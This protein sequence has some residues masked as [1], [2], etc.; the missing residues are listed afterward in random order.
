MQRFQGTVQDANGR[1]VASATVTVFTSGVVNPL[2]VIYHAAGSKT[3]PAV[4]ANPITTD[5]LGNFGFA[6]P[7]GTY[8]VVISG[9]GIPTKTLPNINFF[10]GGITYPSPMLGTVTSVSMTAPALFTV[11]GSPITGS[12]TLVMALA[13]QNKNL[14]LASD[15]VN[16]GVA[17]AMRA[18]VAAD[19]PSVGTAGVKGSATH[20]PVFTTNAQGSVSANTDTLCTPAFSSI[21]GTP[22]TLAGYGITDAASLGSKDIRFYVCPSQN[23]PD[24]GRPKLAPEEHIIP[25]SPN[26]VVRR[27][28]RLSDLLEGN[29][30]VVGT[31]VDEAVG[32]REDQG[33]VKQCR[34]SL[35]I[36][37]LTTQNR[38]GKGIRWGIPVIDIG[39][40]GNEHIALPP[41]HHALI[42]AP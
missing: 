28:A 26:G 15:P 20:I 13:T 40:S 42:P 7:D 19:L 6:A 18:L 25:N 32:P 33:I 36:A 16:N 37:I 23:T 24:A 34:Y 1:A 27:T 35:D 11:G 17:P 21:T 3:A 4:Q 9:G 5:A 29:V 31:R 2:P 14:V 39:E 8:D 38:E 41:S 30:G 12:G 22:T 10:D